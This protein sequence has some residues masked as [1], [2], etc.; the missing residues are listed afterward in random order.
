MTIILS[1]HLDDAVLSLGQFLAA[2]PG[3]VVV[4]VFAGLPE[5]GTLSDYDRSCGFTDSHLAMLERRDEDESA[6]IDLG[7]YAHHLEFLDG[8][9]AHREHEHVDGLREVVRRYLSPREHTLCPLGIGH[10]DHALLA[11]ACRSACPIG[12]TL[13]L[14]E[15]LPYRVLAPEQAFA[16][17]Q[18]FGDAGFELQDWPAPHGELDRKRLALERYRSQFPDGPTDP[19]FY[20]P[21]RVWRATR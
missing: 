13:L 20:V 8:Q 6:L 11:A 16:A 1:P 9:Y 14:Y 17:L 4:T 7:A 10:P 12:G 5:P 3:T 15:E 21:E 19:C 18:A 2:E